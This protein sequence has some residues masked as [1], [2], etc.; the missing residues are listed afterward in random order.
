MNQIIDSALTE[1]CP[2]IKNLKEK[3]VNFLAQK[4]NFNIITNYKEEFYEKNDDIHQVTYEHKD[5]SVEYIFS[6]QRG[7][8][9]IHKFTDEYLRNFIK[10]NEYSADFYYLIKMVFNYFIENKKISRKSKGLMVFYK[11]N[12]II[13]FE[14]NNP[15]EDKCI[16]FDISVLEDLLLECK[17]IDS[18]HDFCL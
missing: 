12:P 10:E 1:Y 2:E 16:H 15:E 7:T 4:I 14:N 6:T 9:L 17:N 11:S 3:Y 5:Y 18:Y 13:F 8:I